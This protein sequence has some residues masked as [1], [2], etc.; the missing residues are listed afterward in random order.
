MVR[1]DRKFATS[2]GTPVAS[3]YGRED[4]PPELEV[5]P[6]GRFPFTRGIHRNMYRERLWTMR[7][8]SGFSTPEETNS[9]Y[10]YLLGQGQ[11]GLSVA[12]DLPTLM[13]YDADHPVAEGE[14][15]KCGAPVSS[16]EDMEGSVRWHSAERVSVSMTINWP[17]IV[18]YGRCIW[19]SPKSRAPACKTHAA[20][21]KM[22]FSR[23]T[24]RRR[25]GFCRRAPSLGWSM[26]SEFFTGVGATLS[27]RF[28]SADTISA[29]P[30]RPRS[31]NWHSRFKTDRLRRSA[32]E[33][34]LA[35]TI[36]RRGS[37]FFLM[38]TAI[39]SKRSRNIV[40]LV[41]SGHGRCAIAMGLRTAR[42]SCV[43]TPRRPAARLPAA[44]VQQCGATAI[45]ALA[46][47]LGGA[48][49]L[50]TNS[51]DET[52]ALPLKK[53]PSSRCARNR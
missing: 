8:F 42:W 30:D 24:S 11:T 52:Y 12:F 53:P 4:L 5:P 13:G 17:G 20:R 39:F 35:S 36:S 50:H 9:R 41:R 27:I 16:L 51:L 6:P 48:Q 28:R 49:S 34:G 3:S 14:V 15:G 32:I 43:F 37:A 40:P 25:N 18:L 44:A 26:T 23:N 1:K 31:R 46:A 10:R 29:R 19:S 47:V 7:Q 45:E 38:R 2:G 33:A 21:C 22:T